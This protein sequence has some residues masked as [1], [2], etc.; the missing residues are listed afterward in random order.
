MHFIFL[1]CQHVGKRGLTNWANVR[2]PYVKKLLKTQHGRNPINPAI[3]TAIG[4]RFMAKKRKLKM[5]TF[6]FALRIVFLIV[7]CLEH[8]M[9]CKSNCKP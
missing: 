7:D 9:D 5:Q 4:H 1:I 6:C 8:D 3:L 2:T